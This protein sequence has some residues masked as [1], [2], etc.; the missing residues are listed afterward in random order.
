MQEHIV[1]SQKWGEF[2]T[3]NGTTAI[4]VGEIQ[5]TKHKIPKTKKYFAY[6]PK[7]N[8]QKINFNELKKSLI[9]NNCININFDVPNVI[10]KSEEIQE[11]LKIFEQ[12]GCIKSPRDQFAKYSVF[13]DLKK[14]ENELFEQMHS[15]HRYNTRYAQRKGVTV[16]EADHNN[17]QDFE[18]FYKLLKDTADRQ[19]YYVHPK[20][21]YLGIWETLPQDMCHILIAEFEGAP[22]AAWML[23]TYKNV[24][25]YPYGGSS[26]EHK[27]L[28]ASNLIGWEAI[29][30][31]KKHDC[32]VFD[33]WGASKDPNDKADPWHG[34]TNFKLKFGGEHVEFMDSYDYVINPFMYKSFN[35]ANK[36]R[37]K[38]LKAIR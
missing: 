32:E 23:F 11:D 10:L 2:K 25:Y 24:L 27:N 38:I 15:K 13:L 8:P 3:K 33:M 34:F 21:Y 26:E 18:I 30:L 16:K 28:F 37:W 14:T 12:N 36:L 4:R 19:K 29:R 5:Y 35:L 20:K 22:L 17:N 7:V 31:G 1:Q 9:E 6:C